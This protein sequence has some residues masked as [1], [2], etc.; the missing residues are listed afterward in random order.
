MQQVLPQLHAIADLDSQ[1]QMLK[2]LGECT[3]FADQVSNPMDAARNIYRI[4]LV[5]MP[6]VES[7]NSSLNA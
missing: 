5:K 4:L 6:H 1:S 7:L 3:M 2:I